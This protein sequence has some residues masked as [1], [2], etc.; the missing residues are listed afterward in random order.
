[1]NNLNGE[2]HSMGF[3]QSGD[4]PVASDYDGD[5]RF[6][7]A[8]FRPSNGTWMLRRS[9]SG[10]FQQPFGTAGDIPVQSAPI[11]R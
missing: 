6:D 2:Y 3:G 8:V 11:A 1:L 4:I 7:A 5:G 10:T 9:A